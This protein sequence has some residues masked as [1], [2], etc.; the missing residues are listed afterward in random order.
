ME[1]KGDK[2]WKK[3]IQNKKVFWGVIILALLVIV[4]LS[5]VVRTAN[6][7]KLIDISTNS[8]TL[9]PDLDPFLYLRHAKEINT[10]TL[11]IPD[12]MRQAPIGARNFATVNMVPALITGLYGFLKIFSPEV[13]IEFAAIIIPV[14]MFSIT[15]FIFFLFALKLFSFMTTKKRA[16]IIALVSTALYAFIPIMLHRTVAGIPEL[17][18]FGMVFLWLAFYFFLFAWDSKKGKMLLFG[19]LSGVSTGLM[20]WTWGGFKYIF[21]TIGLAA[22][23]FFFINKQKKKNFLIY[24]SWLVPALLINLLRQTNLSAFT[25]ITDT[26]F[27]LGIFLILILDFVLS[28][29]WVNKKFK[30]NKIKLPQS[31]ITLLV[32]VVLAIIGTLIF[33]PA[34]IPETFSS[35]L[36][37]LLS[38]FG[39]GRVG[40]TIAENRAPYFTEV[41]GSFGSALVWIFIF[42]VIYLFYAATK[43]FSRKPKWTLNIFFI[44][45]IVTFIFSRISPNS[46]LNGENFISQLIYFGGIIL[47]L[48]TVVIMYIKAYTKEDHKLLGD[49]S[50]INS[51]YIVLLSFVVW[52]I[53]S[54]RGAIRLF[55]IISPALILCASYL[56]VKLSEYWQKNKDGLIKVVLIAGIILCVIF[57]ALTLRDYYQSTS[58]E[59][60]WSVPNAYSQQW[61]LAMGWVR[62]NTPE[63][64]IF[65]HWWDYGYW[66]QTLGER[67]TVTDGGHQNGFW[68][69]TTARYLMTAR[70]EKTALQLCKAHNVSYYLLDSTDVGKYSAYSS[71][72][73][74]E[75]QGDRL[76]W[77]PTLMLNEQQTQ[78]TADG[79]LYF[80]NAGMVLDEDFE[81]EGKLYPR[82]KAAIGA[83]FLLI[84]KE[85]DSLK[86]LSAVIVYNNQQVTV[87]IQWAWFDGILMRVN[88]NGLDSIFYI[89]P[90]ITDTGMNPMGAALY[91]GEK[92]SNSQFTRL[93]LLEQSSNFEL[94]HSEQALV[95]TQLRNQYQLDIPDIIY[96]QGLHGPIK[97]FKVNYPSDIEYY[98]E[99]LTGNEGAWASLDHL[100]T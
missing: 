29:Q 81:W 53:V 31:V 10:G 32:V 44:L 71:I 28:E 97:I 96:A 38:P 63:N 17:E 39:K 95:V 18:S 43:H 54:M 94:V 59:A 82:H 100:G 50:S 99:Y 30:L 34:L 1:E 9:G 7:P 84:D 3:L 19:A 24:A 76:S 72:G 88:E 33:N 23:I 20:M 89:V 2:E 16:G 90:K 40:L 58:S 26:G 36:D 66:V 87:P 27:A 83:V 61:Q 67:P 79:M 75:E 8:Y 77:I 69:H 6:V 48:L 74:H 60:K 98:P 25:S 22:F 11:E 93:Y 41:I 62:E 68:D 12:I 78:E 73:S 45:F 46:F 92:T 70:N 65:V 91:L 85:T 55:F 21:M 15:L 51:A 86:D 13:S 80:Y 47:F 37:G 35:I 5:A 14:V 4:I 52:A 42:G 57:L 56:P 49:F 64:S